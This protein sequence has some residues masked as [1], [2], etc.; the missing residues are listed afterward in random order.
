MPPDSKDA[1][2]SNFRSGFF[3]AAGA[4]VYAGILAAIATFLWGLAKMSFWSIPAAFLAFIL[5]WVAM[6]I[7]LTSP[8][9]EGARTWA[10]QR[11]GWPVQAP[12]GALS[13]PPTPVAARPASEI[14]AGHLAKLWLYDIHVPRFGKEM[15]RARKA[16]A[17]MEIVFRK[18]MERPLDQDEVGELNNQTFEFMEALEKADAVYRICL[19]VN[20]NTSLTD[21][22]RPSHIPIEGLEKL[23]T[24]DLKK[25]YRAFHDRLESIAKNEERMKEGLLSAFNVTQEAIGKAAHAAIDKKG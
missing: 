16:Q 3:Q 18:A 8:R 1:P 7:L 11:L 2:G 14:V 24:D 19:H 6:E 23:P 4:S 22:Y 5:A 25:E 10:R 9:I 13:L 17:R 20:S 15:E 12:A 21:P